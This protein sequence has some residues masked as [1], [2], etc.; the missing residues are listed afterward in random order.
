MPFN[1]GKFIL[2]C[3]LVSP[4][5]SLAQTCPAIDGS[6]LSLGGTFNISTDCSIT[7]T[8]DVLS[9]ANIVIEETGS[10]TITSPTFIQNGGL[11]TVQG[12]DTSP[13]GLVEINGS[14]S[15]DFGANIT[16]EEGAQFTIDGDTFFGNISSTMLELDGTMNITGG[17]Q[18]GSF[19]IL[20]GNGALIVDGVITN[21]GTDD[22][23]YY[24]TVSCNGGA[25][26][27]LPVELI[28][29]SVNA[30]NHYAYLEW[31][32]ATEIDNLG[33]EI[34]KSTNGLQYETI[35]FIE[36]NGTTN[37]KQ[38]YSFTDLNFNESAYYRL[39]QLD[40]HETHV[41]SPTLF[42]Q[43]PSQT[44]ITLFPST[45]SREVQFSSSTNPYT[46]MLTNSFGHVILSHNSPASIE[47]IGNMIN[48]KIPS[49][50]SGLY[51]VKLSSPTGQQT[52]KFLKN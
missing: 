15:I 35:G 13:N 12:D 10:L 31:V 25:C 17:L 5:L 48:Q 19:G 51:L 41:F 52:L 44:N 36:G 32:T 37:Q 38:Y 11:I 39:K 16:I 45:V 34:Q 26:S 22:S 23:G 43:A 21:S 29:F 50:P 7:N 46:M 6:D 40:Y 49:L 33:F 20:S 8:G 3:A 28:S 18:T 47:T 9:N 14:F 27:A 24:G 1:K 30:S 4:I 42:L 2:L